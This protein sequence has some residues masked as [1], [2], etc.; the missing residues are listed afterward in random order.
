MQGS[1]CGATLPALSTDITAD[2]L[3]FATAYRFK[4][5]VNGASYIVSPLGN[6]RYFRLTSLPVPV[7]AGTAYTISVAAQFNGVWGD[8]ATECNVTTPGTAPTSKQETE[9]A[10]ISSIDFS[11]IAYPNPSNSTFYLHVKGTTEDAVSILVFD[12]A[13]RQIENKV[14][15]AIAVETIS[16]SQNYST[17]IYNIIVSQGMN[18]KTLRLVKN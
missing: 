11:L 18:T 6:R 10:G 16:L 7:T 17:G 9:T 8:Y 15:N 3:Q 12:M 2:W 1:Q 14:V 13:G 4:V 5:I